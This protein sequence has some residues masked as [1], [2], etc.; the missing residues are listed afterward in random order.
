MV[1]AYDRFCF[2]GRRAPER[3]RGHASQSER[4]WMRRKEIEYGQ[5][6]EA[7]K[8]A[9]EKRK[10]TEDGKIDAQNRRKKNFSLFCNGLLYFYS[11]LFSYKI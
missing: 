11:L 6:W 9:T 1:L 3:V 8:E 10:R 7:E 5:G 2:S 4:Y